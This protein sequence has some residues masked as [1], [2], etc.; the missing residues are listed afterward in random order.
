MTLTV[1]QQKL[2]LDLAGIDPSPLAA[3]LPGGSNS[4]S[5]Q[6]VRAIWGAGLQATGF[7][8]GAPASPFV[9]GAP[10]WLNKTLAES[11]LELLWNELLELE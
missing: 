9:N 6:M 8:V 5:V 10:S 1:A 7:A 4:I 3:S 11:Q 2:V